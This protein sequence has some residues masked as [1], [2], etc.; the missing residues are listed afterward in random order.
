MTLTPDELSSLLVALDEVRGQVRHLSEPCYQVGPVTTGTDLAI[1][2]LRLLRLTEMVRPTV[3]AGRVPLGDVPEAAVV[4]ADG[5]TGAG[6]SLLEA[7]D[8]WM[9]EDR[10]F[11]RAEVVA[12]VA[13]VLAERTPLGGMRS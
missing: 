4:E 1:L 2:R 6:T 12:L 7:A 11:R 8:Q 13:A 10:I 9:P 5:L 3:A